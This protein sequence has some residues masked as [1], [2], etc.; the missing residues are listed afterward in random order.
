MSPTK[1]SIK[2]INK[3]LVSLTSIAL[4]LTTLAQSVPVESGDDII[5][6]LKNIRDWFASAFVVV[7]T[8]MII[9]AAFLFLTAGDSEERLGKAKSSLLWGVI[10]IIVALFAYGIVEL[11]SSLLTEAPQ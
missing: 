9:Y 1:K 4:P 3:I 2:Y 11:V 5:E 7:S 8:V 6:I 10:G